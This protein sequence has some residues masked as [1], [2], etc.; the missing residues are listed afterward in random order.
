MDDAGYGIPDGLPGE[1]FEPSRIPAKNVGLYSG[2][3][4]AGLTASIMIGDPLWSK[5]IAVSF[6]GFISIAGI[7]GAATAD[8]KLLLVQ[9]VPALAGIAALFLNG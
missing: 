8:R 2:F 9:T 7:F 3:P 6:L 5:N 1:T 4:A